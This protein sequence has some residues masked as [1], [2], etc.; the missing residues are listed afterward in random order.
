[1]TSYLLFVLKLWVATLQQ[2]GFDLHEYLPIEERLAAHSFHA[3]EYVTDPDENYLH[4]AATFGSIVLGHPNKTQCEAAD[5]NDP[6]ARANAGFEEFAAVLGTNPDG[7]VPVPGTAL[8]FGL[9]LVLVRRMRRH[10][11]V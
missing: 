1:M 6:V 3:Y 2:I 5:N 10:R 4:V 8:L 7:E 9:G 11:D